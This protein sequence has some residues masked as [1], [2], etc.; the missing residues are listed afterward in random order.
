MDFDAVIRSR[1]SCRAYQDRPVGAALVSDIISLAVNAPSAG[2][3]QEWRIVA[4]SDRDLVT[5]IALEAGD[6]KWWAGAP[7]ILACCADTD[8]HVMRCRQPCYTVDV[9]IIM[10]HIGLIAAS[11]GLGSCW[12]GAFDEDAVKNICAIPRHIRVVGLLTLGY[13][14][15][16]PKEKKRLPVENVLFSNRWEWR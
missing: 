4:V 13:P 10:D 12:L 7:V 14:A 8:N 11:R 6:Q 15:D 16:K 5:R 3:R 9:S 2:N 1:Y